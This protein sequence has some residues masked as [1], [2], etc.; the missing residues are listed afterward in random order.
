[1]SAVGRVVPLCS[2]LQSAGAC[3]SRY[4][5][6]VVGAAIAGLIGSL[7]PLFAQTTSFRNYRCADGTEFIV[8]SYPYDSHAYLQIDGGPV[9]LKR[10]LSISGSRYSGGG[11][12]LKISRAGR[13]TV[14]HPGRPE[15]AC[16]PI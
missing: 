13:T 9:T 7:T 5:N 8:A 16:G 3:M 1:M 10:R 14:K 15:T 4:R 11:V 6:I 2:I 12:T